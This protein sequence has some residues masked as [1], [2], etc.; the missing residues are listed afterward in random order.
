MIHIC[1]WYKHLSLYLYSNKISNRLNNSQQFSQPTTPVSFLR[2]AGGLPR[3][4]PSVSHRVHL[5]GCAVSQVEDGLRAELVLTID[6]LT[7]STTIFHQQ[8]VEAARALE[9]RI[10]GWR[11]RSPGDASRGTS[12]SGDSPPIG[13]H[14]LIVECRCHS[15]NTRSGLQLSVN[16]GQDVLPSAT[17]TRD[18]HVRVALLE[19]RVAR[20]GALVACTG[21][22]LYGHLERRL[23]LQAASSAAWRAVG[24]T[25]W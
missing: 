5:E 17:E 10:V 15:C 20:S 13:L 11:C 6:P 9:L 18:D 14:A 2:C 8:A 25:A 16:L 3:Q 23:R 19:R 4:L 1:A 22:V 24:V 12:V 21:R 7:P